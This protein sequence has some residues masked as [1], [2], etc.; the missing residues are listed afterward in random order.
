MACMLRLCSPHVPPLHTRRC[1]LAAHLDYFRLC[2]GVQVRA[3]PIHLLPQPRLRVRQVGGAV[4]GGDVVG[5]LFY[6][7]WWGGVR[8]G[9]MGKKEG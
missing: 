7:G 4:A 9:V 1:V 6:V 8:G 5:G 2:G 3:H